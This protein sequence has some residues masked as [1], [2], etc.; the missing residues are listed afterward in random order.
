MEP[1]SPPRAGA[2][3]SDGADE[4]QALQPA[5]L[6]IPPEKVIR[7]YKKNLNVLAQYAQNLGEQAKHDLPSL[8]DLKMSPTVVEELRLGAAAFR[9]AQGV[10]TR[11][12]HA[13]PEALAQWLAVQPEMYRTSVE[14]RQKLEFAFQGRGDLLRALKDMRNQGRKREDL[15]QQICDFVWIGRR[16][17]TLLENVNFDLNRLDRAFEQAD[18]GFDI[19]SRRDADMTRT[20]AKGIRNRTL[21]FVVEKMKT[22][23]RYG[24]QAFLGNRERQAP[25]RDPW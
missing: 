8:V 5:L 18:S 7:N 11:I 14:L 9:Y 6:T 12:A 20:D 3:A 10:W 21:T 4:F 19:I 24:L 17:H 1:D 22:V 25:Y 23:Q 13:R 16:N 2:V 15:V